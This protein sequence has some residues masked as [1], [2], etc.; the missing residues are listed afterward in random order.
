MDRRSYSFTPVYLFPHQPTHSRSRYP[1]FLATMRTASCQCFFR[2]S[3]LQESAA[4]L[5]R[6][7]NHALEV[8]RLRNPG[9]Y[10]MI[11]T[12]AANLQQANTTTRIACRF[13]QHS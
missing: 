9:D 12:L 11:L 7:R 6:K 13:C 10:W 1:L 8:S 3:D 5:F 2:L 4:E